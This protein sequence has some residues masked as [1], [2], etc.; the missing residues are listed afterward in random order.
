AEGEKALYNQ[1]KDDVKLQHQDSSDNKI[2]RMVEAID[3]L[4]KELGKEGVTIENVREAIR[5]R[6][7]A[8]KKSGSKIANEN[9]LNDPVIDI[10]FN[11]YTKRIEIADKDLSGQPIKN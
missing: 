1:T 2:E 7:E 4:H 10:A 3:A 11:E 9:L 8:A 5:Q 6:I